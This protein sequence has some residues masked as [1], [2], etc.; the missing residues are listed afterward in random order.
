MRSA[1]GAGFLYALATDLGITAPDIM[2]AS[3]GDAGS[4]LYF[5]AG[6]YHGI[7]RIWLDLL[8][9]RR[10][11][12]LLRFW[13]IMDIDYL[14][15]VVFKEQEP[16]DT[17]RLQRTL[18]KWFIPLSDYDTGATCYVGIK[19]NLDPF[20][21]LRAAK[22][23]PVLFGKRILLSHRRYI[24][25]ELGPILQ[26]HVRHALA[27]GVQNILI[28]NHVTPWEGTKKIAMRLY[29]SVI[30]G[31][32]RDAIIRDISTDTH[33]FSAPHANVLFVSPEK[34]PC[35]PLTHNKEKI[36]A[37]FD[38]GVA[39]ALALKDELRALFARA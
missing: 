23:I 20:E 16:L 5:C 25:G 32:M 18:I 34:L 31:G 28:L 19:D 35:A 8:S 3:S 36:K 11:I 24:D 17:E 13:R 38:R 4:T 10:F 9:T 39:D 21:V 29:T 33:H 15:D 27:Q 1:H 14:I 2:I 37:T 30:P 6:Q 7:R 26:D 22:A 12:S